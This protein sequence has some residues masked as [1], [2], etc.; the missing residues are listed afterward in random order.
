MN[1]LFEIGT[2]E[3]PASY[4]SNAVEKLKD[5]FIKDFED[6]K[7]TYENIYTYSTPR[8][9]AIK[10]LGLA[11]LQQDETIEK[12]GPAKNVAI[13]AN[14]GFTK[15]G[16]G[17]LKSSNASENDVFFIS[18]NKGEYIAV[19]V[20]I[21]GRETKDLLADMMDNALKRITFPKTM[22][23][24][25]NTFLFAR[26]IQW[27]LAI[28]DNSDLGE[29]TYTVSN[30]TLAGI[31]PANLSFGNRYNNL[32]NKIEVS[33][34]NDYPQILKTINVVAD[35]EER[36]HII[37]NGIKQ[38]TKGKLDEKLLDTVTDL[39]EFP[40][41]VKAAFS[42]EYLE[43]P[44]KIITSTLSQNQKYFTIIDEQGKLTNEFI[45]ISNGDPEFSD[46]IKIGNE[47][48]VK[49][50]L[51]DARFYFKED[52]KHSLEFYVEKLDDV[53]FQTK[54]GTMLD[55][56]KRVMSL[57]ETLTL[58]LF[59]EDNNLLNNIK[60]AAFLCK[61]DLVTQMIG[62]KEF[63]ALQGYIGMNYAM[64]SGENTDVAKAI[65]EHY[66]PRGQNDSLPSTIT[67]AILAI[68]DKIDTVSG[69]IAVGLMPTGSADP[70]AIRRAGNGIVQIIDKFEFDFS[71]NDLVEKAFDAFSEY[72]DKKAA[73]IK[74][75]KQR[76]MWLLEE[77]HRIDYDIIDSIDMLNWDNLLDIKKRA[78]ALQE[79]KL[80]GDDF[81]ILVS[82][83]KRVSN[84]LN[85]NN[86]DCPLQVELL[87]DENEI[88][89]YEQLQKTL[90]NIEPLL[91]NKNYKEVV[92][93]ILPIGRY[94][95]KLFDNVLVICDDT[96]IRNNRLALLNQIKNVFLLVADINKIM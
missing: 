66:M 80:Y 93:N 11:N 79:L 5:S 46:I 78:K 28:Y 84:I 89:L 45:F 96:I 20:F 34:V 54:L 81:V 62:E 60:R 38:Y 36:K 7:L 30:C 91:Q 22:K 41:A 4:I 61:A 8:R 44:Q 85:K 18:T 51:D 15:A 9:L 53:V 40:T 14:G 29:G 2:E 52:T 3:I 35:R 63:T 1:F 6:L 42:E 33:S 65:Y 87:T 16:Y 69:I 21:K 64:L 71:I 75:L 70:F 23:W 74:F 72:Q 37:A 94:I 13:D 67:S 32:M 25:N 83:F 59:K 95:D 27:I 77:I 49:A 56:T 26:P 88:N 24:G 55:K 48:V 17:F 73:V 50:R 76:M 57:A 68:A 92:I 58:K 43:L 86:A 47:K 12:T 10:I 19:K 31:V 82:A 90:T 39:V